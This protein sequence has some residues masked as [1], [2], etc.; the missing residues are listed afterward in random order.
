MLAKINSASF[1]GIDAYP[2]TIEVDVAHG[3][4]QITIVGLPDQV[5]KESK[6]RV[7]AAIRNSGYE[8]PSQRVTINLAPADTKKEGPLF[9]LPIAIGWLAASGYIQRNALEQFAFLGELALDGSLKPTKGILA[10]ALLFRETP[11][12]LI[13]PKENCEEASLAEGSSVECA[14]SLKDAVDRLNGKRALERVRYKAPRIEADGAYENDWKDVRGQKLAKRAFEVAA[15]GGHNLLLIGSPG[16]GKTLMAKCLPS[17]LPPA[18]LEELLTTIRIYSITYS[19]QINNLRLG[20]RPFR[21]PHHSISTAGLVGGGSFPRPGE[22]SLAHSGVLFLDELA[23]YRRDTLEALRGPL[24]DGHIQI[25]RARAG[26]W[27]PARFLLVAAM[28]PC[29]CGYLFDRRKKCRCS[30]GEIRRYHSR[31]SGPI[32]DRID[33]HLEIPAIGYEE[34]RSTT[35]AESSNSIRQRVVH[36]RQIQRDRYKGKSFLTNGALP[37][38]LIQTYCRASESTLKLLDHAMQ[39]LHLSARAFHR[40]L[41]VART[42]A[43]LAESETIQEEHIAE[44]IQYRTLDRN[45]F[46]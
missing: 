39:G 6:E 11:R 5:V 34:I 16:A 46:G 4:P 29:P 43:D 10:A 41:K 44:A 8:I 27:L 3:L 12:T 26:V 13:I 15:S 19:A 40:I 30:M 14:A 18:T 23:E 35:E 21:A 1:L 17:I 20:K 38:R 28:N 42:I 33:I 9:D 7:R 36:T 45:W 32:L 2:V 24:E 22:I 31:I 37:A 25:S